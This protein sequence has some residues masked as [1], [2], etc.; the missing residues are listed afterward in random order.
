M[1]PS[2]PRGSRGGRFDQ[3][4]DRMSYAICQPLAFILALFV[5]VAWAAWAHWQASVTPGS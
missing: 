4:A 2:Q 5:V 3:F 1:A